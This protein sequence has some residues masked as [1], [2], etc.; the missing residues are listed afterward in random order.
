MMLFEYIKCKSWKMSSELESR[1]LFLVN[2][3]WQGG[4]ETDFVLLSCTGAGLDDDEREKVLKVK[5]VRKEF[6][7]LTL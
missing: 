5:Q 7:I 2:L 1:I 6:P 3:C 4:Q